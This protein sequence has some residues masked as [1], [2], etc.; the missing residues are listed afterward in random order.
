MADEFILDTD[1]LQRRMEGAMT[2][3]RS[4]F[5]SLRTGRASASM[6]EPVMVLSLIHI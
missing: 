1:D 6:L 5:S 4:E 3:L 2:A